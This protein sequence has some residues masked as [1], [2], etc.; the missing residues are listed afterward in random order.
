MTIL[1]A[2][3]EAVL[4]FCPKA[5]Y[6]KG[7][8]ERWMSDSTEWMT[9]KWLTSQEAESTLE[10]ATTNSVKQ[11]LRQKHLIVDAGEGWRGVGNAIAQ[12]FPD[13]QVVGVDRR[14]H[15]YTGQ[16]QGVITSAVDHDFTAAGKTD[17]ITTIAKKVGRS[18]RKWMMLWV[19]PE[20]SPLSI[21]NAMNQGSGTAHGMWA[22]TSQNQSN[23]SSER[24][25][26]EAEYLR[27]ALVA[28][29]NIVA[30]LQA[31]PH[32]KFALEN[33]ATSKM[34]D[35]DTVKEA[36]ARNVTWRVARVDQCTY[37]R[38]SQ[39]PTKILTNISQWKPMG[40]T[41]TGRCVTGK[42]AGT[43]GNRKGERGHAEQTIPSV[44]SKRPDQ[45]AKI[46]GKR[47]RTREAV[48]NEVAAGLVCEIVRAA[49]REE[50]LT[51]E[52]EEE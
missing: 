25:A 12:Q 17:L 39:K 4:T 49:R 43:I 46:G 52:P 9:G 11:V 16:K 1:T 38:K 13:T 42:C 40:C 47:E 6:K 51:E 27:E 31:H 5:Q 24:A 34:W 48:V 21:G 2:N 22:L 33:P 45:G 28:L 29:K 30:A 7:P 20:C 23:C 19:S 32:L 14:G 8:W 41:G 36:I 3:N 18:A 44:K 10:A 15:T 37:G 35:L 50:G 26:Q